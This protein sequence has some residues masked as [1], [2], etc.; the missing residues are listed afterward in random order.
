MITISCKTSR[1]NLSEVKEDFINDCCFGEDFSDWF[2]KELSKNGADSDV[3][4]MEDFGWF[5]QVE[6][7]ANIYGL[8]ISGYSEDV[9]NLPNYGSWF[10][11]FTKKRKFMETLLGKNKESNEEPVFEIVLD[12]L[13]KAGFDEVGFEST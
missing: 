7:N 1:F 13:L 5:N 11:T 6:I 8:A 2:T 12:I 9:S 10:L 3:V 4:C